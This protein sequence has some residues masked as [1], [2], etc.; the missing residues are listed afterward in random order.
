MHSKASLVIGTNTSHYNSC[1]NKYCMNFW[2]FFCFGIKLSLRAVR[3]KP[4]GSKLN[5]FATN[6]RIRC[7]GVPL[8]RK[9]RDAVNILVS[10]TNQNTVMQT[11]SG[12]YP[13]CHS[14]IISCLHLSFSVSLM[15]HTPPQTLL[16]YFPLKTLKIDKTTWM[17]SWQHLKK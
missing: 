11:R 4:D 7:Q 2:P 8:D 15:L 5:L 17:V 14:I 9:V 3:E 16:S 10:P 12:H 1:N 13:D 6:Q